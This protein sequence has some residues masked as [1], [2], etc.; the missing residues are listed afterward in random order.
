MRYNI[1]YIGNLPFAIEYIIFSNYYNLKFVVVEK[2]RLTDDLLTLLE[3]R[4]IK[5][6]EVENPI[7]ILRIK[8]FKE[9]DFFIM[10]SYGRKIPKQIIDKI[11]IY[12]I[13]FGELPYYKGRHPTFYA[14]MSNELRPGIS[15]HKIDES[16]DEGDIISIEKVN[17]FYNENES[18]LFIKLQKKI[19]NLLNALVLYLQDNTKKNNITQKGKYFKP[20]SD[21]DK[22]FSINDKFDKIYNI[23]RAQSNFDGG[24]YIANNGTVFW[25]KE[26]RLSVIKQEYIIKDDLIYF[27]DKL[28]GIK[29]KKENF[30]K[31]IKYN[32]I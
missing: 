18:D 22:I 12:N 4:N 24:K 19:P 7:D 15:I 21:N 16:I 23:I 31:L 29:Y 10:C 6:Y 25:I 1:G 2:G 30:I 5:Y 32:N 9:I 20:V 26:I 28:I 11:A 13:H 27:K 3:F 17:Y 14:T 8:L